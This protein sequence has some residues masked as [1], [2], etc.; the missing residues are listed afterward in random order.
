MFWLLIAWRLLN[1]SLL[2][3]EYEIHPKRHVL[4]LNVKLN[5]LQFKYEEIVS[6]IVYVKTFSSFGSNFCTTIS[7][8]SS[9]R[10]L[11]GW[12]RSNV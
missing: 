6:K 2:L 7:K 3:L 12:Y 1:G 10:F 4:S 8:Y 9:T 5:N 11:K